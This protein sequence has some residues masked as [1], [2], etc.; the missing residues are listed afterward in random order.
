MHVGIVFFENPCTVFLFSGGVVV[1]V[2]SSVRSVVVVL[3]PRSVLILDS[4]HN[5]PTLSLDS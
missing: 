5:P 1:A 2:R 3:S 4:I